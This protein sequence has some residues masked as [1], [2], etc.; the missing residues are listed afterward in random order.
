MITHYSHNHCT[1]FTA[2]SVFIF[3]IHSSLGQYHSSTDSHTL[4][5]KVPS[6]KVAAR[7]I[8][9]LKT[10]LGLEH[11]FLSTDATPKGNTM[12]YCMYSVNNYSI[13]C[14]YIH[15]IMSIT[16]YNYRIRYNYSQ[17]WE[18]ITCVMIN[19]FQN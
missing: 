15:I 1:M 18:P 19:Q 13:C 11:V 3:I 5:E 14:T 7:Q 16:I 17:L 2:Y 9:K 4:T 10:K 12:F 8:N 6:L